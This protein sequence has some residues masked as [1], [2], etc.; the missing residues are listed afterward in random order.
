M[1]RTYTGQSNYKG[2]ELE[3]LLCLISRITVML[4]W[5]RQFGIAKNINIKSVEQNRE[6]R[7]RH[8]HIWTIDFFLKKVLRQFN[9]ERKVFNKWARITENADGIINIWKINLVS[10]IDLN[11]KPKTKILEEYIGKGLCNSGIHKRFLE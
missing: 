9:G 8:L 5:S 11:V 6:S 2:T 1:Q 7:N 4:Q 3:N 10:I